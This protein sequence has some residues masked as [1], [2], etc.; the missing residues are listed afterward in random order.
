MMKLRF[1]GTG[2]STGVPQIGCTCPTCISTDIHDKRL[3][4]S[5]L[6]SVD[7]KNIL[8]D[9]GPD[10]RQQIIDAGAPDLI[11]ALL[12]HSHY[13]H[14]G[15]IDDLRPYC[16]RSGGFPLYCRHDVA[17]D[18]RA[19]VPYCFKEHPYPGV[20][21]FDIHEIDDDRFSIGDIVA[22]P[23]PVIHYKLP[24]VGFRVGKLAY[25][26]DAKTIPDSS[27][28]RL[29]GVDTL[30]INALRKEQH[31]S[32]MNLEEALAVIERVGPRVAYLTHL[33]DKMGTQ[34]EVQPMLPRN[35]YIA[36]DGLEIEI[37]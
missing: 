1:L 18:L 14:V 2:T 15:G 16:Y 6:L 21:I 20:P 37:V 11:A 31:L 36:Y 27:Y 33:A 13:D 9:C 12:T 25:I 7:G 10:F 34:A 4:A 35:V 29:E 22:L 17:D 28:K 30:V 8:I 3:R 19:R 32:H 26:T 5:A 23:I 24:I